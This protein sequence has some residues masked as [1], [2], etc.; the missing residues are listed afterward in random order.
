MILAFL[1]L[2]KEQII[3]CL[4]LLNQE[5][6][7]G[8]D[9]YKRYTL[10]TNIKSQVKDWLE[11]GIFPIQIQVLPLSE[12]DST[13]GVVNHLLIIDPLTPVFYNGALPQRAIDGVAAGTAMVDSNGKV[14]G[15]PTYSNGEVM[16]PVAETNYRFRGNIDTDRM[17]STVYAKLTLAEGL[18]VTSRD[19]KDQIQL[20]VDGIQFTI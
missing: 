1:G 7:G 11:V 14:Y 6:I 10:R 4:E 8:A 15:Y 3:I 18:T 2:Q 19:M 12:D 9:A 13:G 16:N 17:L 20:I 5:G